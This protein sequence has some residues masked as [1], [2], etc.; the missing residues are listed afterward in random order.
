[1]SKIKNAIDEILNCELCEGKG[2]VNGWVA[3]D[4]DYDFEW[5]DCNPAHLSVEEYAEP[6]LDTCIGCN[7]NRV[8]WDALY[9]MNCYLAK[10]AEIDYAEIDQLWTTKENA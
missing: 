3:P 6:K 8:S 10:N 2:M 1:M 7:E 5:C 4:G 9:C